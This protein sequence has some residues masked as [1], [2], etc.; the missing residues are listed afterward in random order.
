MKST[1]NNSLKVKKLTIIALFCAMSFTVSVLLPIFVPPF[2]TLDFKDA[3]SAIGGMFFGPVA[4]LFCAIVVPFI[5]FITSP[6][7][8]VYGLIMN[9]L[10]SITFVGVS[11]LIYKYK[12]TIW[13]A[14]SGLLAAVFATVSVMLLANLFITPY[15]MGVTQE[16]VIGLIPKLLLP[17][18]LIK[19]IL[20]ASIV[21]LIYKPIS[22]VLKRMG[23]SRSSSNNNSANNT[24][25]ANI[26]TRS[27]V[28]TL[29]SAAIVV[30]A[31]LVLFLVL[32][33][34]FSK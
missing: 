17:F 12:K 28:V 10:S 34:T 24:S 27:L 6:K 1:T 15:Y 11:T 32:G 5:E 9:L 25:S 4:G 2:L 16:T 22:K 18:N 29:V 33:G 13:G 30:V 26:K 14:V 19:T 20:N 3:I 31:S 21:M 7:T 23:L 8:G